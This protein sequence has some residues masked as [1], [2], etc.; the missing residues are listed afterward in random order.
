MDGTGMEINDVSNL[1]HDLRAQQIRN[2]TAQ[3]TGFTAGETPV[4]VSPVRQVAGALHEPENIDDGHRHQG[5]PQMSQ[6]GIGQ[7]AANNLHSV[8]FVPVNGATHH[9]NGPTPATMHHF[10]RNMQRRVGVEFGHR[11]FNGLPGAGLDLGTGNIKR[12]AGHVLASPLGPGF[13]GL[14]V[15]LGPVDDHTRDIFACGTLNAFKAGG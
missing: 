3:G 13:P 12:R 7:H 8:D 5:A 15:L 11:H 9:Q 4:Q 1:F 6:G 14:L 10:H 2:A